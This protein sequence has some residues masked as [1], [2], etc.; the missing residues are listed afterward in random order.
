MPRTAL[1]GPDAVYDGLFR[2]AGV[3]RADDMDEMLDFLRALAA[4]PL[5]PGRRMAVIT[6]SGGPG[7]SL[8][9]HLEKE[10]ITVPPFSEGLREKLDAATG[11]F[12]FVR[13]PIDLTFEVD[14]SIFKR[15]LEI[16]FESG[17]R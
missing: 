12:A 13:N 11:R 10:G 6:N 8:A 14:L 1:S 16:V 2:Q 9:Y 15:L 4:Q 3:I 5:P 7:T 17:H